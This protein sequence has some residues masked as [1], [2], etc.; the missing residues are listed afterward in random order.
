MDEKIATKKFTYEIPQSVDG[1][2]FG[3]PT[4]FALHELVEN[5]PCGDCKEEAVSFM[6]FWH[7]LKN[8]EKGKKIEYKKNFV[9]WINRISSLK[10]KT[11]ILK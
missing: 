11:L 2:I 7:D 3:P 5:I 9:Y 1:A 10:R 8:W 6:R 4:W